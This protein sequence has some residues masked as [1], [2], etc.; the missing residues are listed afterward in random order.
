MVYSYWRKFSIDYAC[1]L[2]SWSTLNAAVGTS[3]SYWSV[4]VILEIPHNSN[5]GQSFDIGA[6][7]KAMDEIRRLWKKQPRI[8]EMSQASTIISLRMV[9][10]DASILG[11]RQVK[12]QQPCGYQ[13]LRWIW[14]CII[15]ITSYNLGQR[16]RKTMTDARRGLALSD[17]FW[18]GDPVLNAWADAYG[19]LVVSVVTV[20]EVVVVWWQVLKIWGC[21]NHRRR[22]IGIWRGF[23]TVPSLIDH[24]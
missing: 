6:N 7:L 22:G 16:L 4:S 13:I 9:E 12:F 18:P 3:I 24:R 8:R 21:K 19:G 10:A 11:L 20:T 14:K 1:G 2:Y 23:I 17:P 15:S 5:T